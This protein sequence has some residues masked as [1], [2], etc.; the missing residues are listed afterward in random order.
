[1]LENLSRVNPFTYTFPFIVIPTNDICTMCRYED[2]EASLKH[3]ISVCSKLP[4]I[5]LIILGF[6]YFTKL[7]DQV[8]ISIGQLI[9][10]IRKS[11]WPNE[12]G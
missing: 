9:S 11:H 10:F 3:I 5:T 12:R 7:G 6:S 8:D 2:E 4:E 1:M